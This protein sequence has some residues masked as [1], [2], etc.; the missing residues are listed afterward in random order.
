MCA[1][2]NG[3]NGFIRTLYSSPF[4][5]ADAPLPEVW[6]VLAQSHGAANML[7]F[8]GSGYRHLLKPLPLASNHRHNCSCFV[9]VG[10]ATEVDA[11][12]SQDYESSSRT[13]AQAHQKPRQGMQ[14]DI[15]T[16]CMSGSVKSLPRVVWHVWKRVGIVGWKQHLNKVL[17]EDFFSVVPNTSVSLVN[18][19][20][21]H[22]LFF[23]FFSPSVPVR[24]FP[25]L[26][27]NFRLPTLYP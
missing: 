17:G 23:F 19:F 18:A 16:V 20:L 4:G 11:L 22:V 5:S 8:L 15:D 7:N 3:S 1:C 24:L 27:W 6:N 9:L 14:T 26:G 10:L 12:Q 2:G 13:Q 21:S 25:L